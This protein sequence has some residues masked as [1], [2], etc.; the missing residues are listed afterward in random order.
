MEVLR[1]RLGIG[2]V[3]AIFVPEAATELILSG[4]APWTCDSMREFQ[5]RVI[6]LQLEREATAFGQAALDG[7]IVICDRGICDSRAYLTEE[8][9][10]RAL[11]SNGIIHDQAL[12]RYDA[13]FHLDTV[14]KD[15]PSAYTKANNDARFENAQEAV[16]AN[17]RVIE[18]WSEHPSL[19]VIGN[20]D[21]FDEKADALYEAIMDVIEEPES[22]ES[23]LVSAC[24]LGEP[25]RYDGLSMPCGAAIQ[26]ARVFELVPVCPEQLGDLPT[27]RTPS[28]IQPDGRVV[29]ASGADKTASFEAGAR[30]T[31]RIAREKG[32]AQAILK[33]NSP[34]CGVHRIYDGTFSGTLIPGQGKTAQLLADA[35]IALRSE[36]DMPTS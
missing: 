31:L 25:C 30:A 29:D 15:Y 35:G 7:S 4:V 22:K 3:R 18:A 23:I 24:L 20:F 19:H 10:Q 33:E 14:A 12:C 9:Y 17:E 28:E 2:G 34:S 21:S 5:T 36:A 16:L 32:C 27:P 13:V 8:G 6:A 11:E 26:L 1:E